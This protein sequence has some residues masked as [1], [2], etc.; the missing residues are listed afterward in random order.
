[1]RKGSKV[2]VGSGHT[3]SISKDPWLSDHTDGFVSFNLNEELAIEL[4]SS[5]M[6]PNQRV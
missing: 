3:F 5:L 1:M 2:Q 4:V 6:L